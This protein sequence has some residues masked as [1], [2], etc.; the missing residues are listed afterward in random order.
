MGQNTRHLTSGS[1]S[2]KSQKS[3]VGNS[4]LSCVLSESNLLQVVLLHDFLQ[5]NTEVDT[6]V[7]TLLFPGL[8]TWYPMVPPAGRAPRT[9]WGSCLSPAVAVY[10]PWCCW[11]DRELFLRRRRLKRKWSLR[12]FLK[13]CYPQQINNKNH[14]IVLMIEYPY[15]IL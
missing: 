8:K 10:R 7:Y 14:F 2:E 15:N 12:G 4:S 5:E 11:S 3:H 9:T 13:C 1:D 6:E